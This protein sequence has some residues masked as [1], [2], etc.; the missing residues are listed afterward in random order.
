MPFSLHCVTPLS[1][2]CPER[3]QRWRCSRLK[4]VFIY[5]WLFYFASCASLSSSGVSHELV[6]PSWYVQQILCSPVFHFEVYETASWN[7]MELTLIENFHPSVASHP[8]KSVRFVSRPLWVR[9]FVTW[10]TCCK[11]V[12]FITSWSHEEFSNINSTDTFLVVVLFLI[13]V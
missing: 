5:M 11:Y 12:V 8:Q 9:V 7:R 2:S 3:R 6:F 13:V 4:N 10:I 1:Q